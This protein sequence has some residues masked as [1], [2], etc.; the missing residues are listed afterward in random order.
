ME[1]AINEISIRELVSNIRK[2]VLYLFRKWK[3]F[4]IIG[5]LGAVIGFLY[6]F[7]TKPQYTAYLT[8]ALEEKGGGIS[9]YASV[10]SQF[11]IDLGGGKEGGA[12][13]GDNI[14]ELLKTKFLIEKTLLTEVSIDDKT[15]LLL[16][17]YIRFNGLD[18]KWQKREETKQLKFD[19][20]T[21]EEH[22]TRQQD[23]VLI[24]IINELKKNS[25]EISKIDKKL[26]I[27]SVSFIS[28]DEQFAKYFIEQLVKNASEF[29][30]DTKTK[31]SRANVSLLEHRLDSVKTAL[32]ENMY[33]Y[34]FSQDRNQ[35]I[36]KA[37]SRVSANEQQLNI[38][39][40]TALYG[41]LVKNLELSKLNLMREEP[42]VQVIDTP[43]FPLKKDKPGKAVSMIVFSIIACSVAAGY[44][45]IQ[46]L[47]KDS[48]P[49]SVGS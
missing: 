17:R 49:T 10:A 13:S 5:L 39:L 42:L 16:N 8:F 27:V 37:Q 41:E 14:L 25:I 48:Q 23:S 15:D 9:A 34:A 35:N 44:F 21:K 28:K 4:I 11:G 7:F 20:K 6:A 1:N 33:G 43:V 31:K 45:I 2:W 32:S 12:F 38:Q 24:A 22:Y 40:L 46:K 18:E 36:V 26:N 19:T 29:Y 47:Y 3:F 30:I